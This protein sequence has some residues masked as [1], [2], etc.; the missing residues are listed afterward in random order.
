VKAGGFFDPNAPGANVLIGQ[1]G[2]RDFRGALILLPKC[3]TS[4]GR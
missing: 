3:E 1:R 2:S 4:I